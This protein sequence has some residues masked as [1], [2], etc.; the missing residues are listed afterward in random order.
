MKKVIIIIITFLVLFFVG[1]L[2]V[3]HNLP[4]G[5]GFEDQFVDSFVYRFAQ[6]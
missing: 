6:S 5:E 3:Y 4:L 1:I 2:T